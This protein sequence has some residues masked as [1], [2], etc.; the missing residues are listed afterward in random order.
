MEKIIKAFTLIELMIVISIIT[1]TTISST[2][3]FL[4]FV[5]NKEISQKVELINTEL[6]SLDKEVKDYKIFDYELNFNTSTLSWKYIIYKNIFD[7]TNYQNVRFLSN[8]YIWLIETNWLSTLTWSLKLYKENKLFL[9]TTRTWTIDYEFTFNDKSKYKI[10]WTLNE[11]NLNEIYINYFDE[12][13]LYPEKN[14]FLNLIKIKK[15]DWDEINNI[16]I[17]NIWWIKKFETNNDWTEINGN[18]ISLVFENNWIEK[19]INII[20]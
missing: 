11:E 1:I 15:E 4:D 20:K 6:K 18:K 2:F 16:Q 13:N 3:Y 5:K 9:N 17:K 12:D 14:N 8:S 7:T 10:I 19:E